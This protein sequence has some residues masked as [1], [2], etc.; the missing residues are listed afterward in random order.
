MNVIRLFERPHAEALRLVSSGA[1]VYVFLNPVEF[2]GPHLPLNTDYLISWNLAQR[3]HERIHTAL[4]AG[5]EVLVGDVIQLGVDPAPGPG[6][7]HT[8]R[9]ELTRILLRSLKGLVKLGVQR[10]VFM[11]F[12]GSPGQAAVIEKGIRW[13]RSQGVPSLNPFNLVLQ[14]L[15]EYDPRR[16]DSVFALIS[17]PRAREKWRAQMGHDFH[18]GMLETSFLLDLAPEHVAPSYQELPDAPD[19]R[20][21]PLL[22]AA[23]QVAAVLGRQRLSTELRFASIAVEWTRLNPHPGYTGAPRWASPEMG[24]LLV[25]DALRDYARA[26]LATFREGKPSPRA[27]MQWAAGY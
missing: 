24:A 3:L 5:S 22:R 14:Q 4:A 7:Q 8:P 11:T 13:L 18:G 25:E 20:G 19:L 21:A 9:R 15:I 6:S 1:P 26:A 10:V 12:H 27:V 16:F 17:E 2:H 23:A